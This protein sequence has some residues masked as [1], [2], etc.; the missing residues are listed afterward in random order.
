LLIYAALAGAMHLAIAFAWLFLYPLLVKQ[1]P[2][3]TGFS[4]THTWWI[5]NI[6]FPYSGTAIIAFL[7]GVL[8]WIPFNVWSDLWHGGA[9]WPFP[10][11]W[12]KGRDAAVERVIL[13]GRRPLELTL[14]QS[15]KTEKHVLLSLTNGKVYI[16]IIDATFAPDDK[17]IRVWPMQ[18]GYRDEKQ[19]LVITTRY[20]EAYDLM[21]A[22]A[23]HKAMI[24]DFRV[25][26]SI[27][28]LISATLYS[29]E[30]HET[31]FPPEAQP[32]RLPPPPP[33]STLSDVPE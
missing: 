23:K 6:S 12:R 5:T 21:S 14:L 17:T 7:V 15:V 28:T 3:L 9:P 16:G 30:L 31:Y 29:E 24:K 25:V 10:D 1:G 27:D 22:V 11:H 8:G 26:I 32:T 13:T 20:D 2:P 18:S 19:R 4:V 33:F